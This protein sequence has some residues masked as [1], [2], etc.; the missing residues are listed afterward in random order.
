MW[1]LIDKIKK[2]CKT[3]PV[4]GRGGPQGCETWRLPHFSDSLLTEVV[5]FTRRP[6][7]TLC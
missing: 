6:P 2:K 4:T 1:K 5:S 3:V 7:F